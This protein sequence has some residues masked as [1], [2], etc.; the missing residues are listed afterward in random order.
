MYNVVY[1]IIHTIYINLISKQNNFPLKKTQSKFA[2][3]N[4]IIIKIGCN[5]T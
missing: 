2:K 5:G 4:V 1:Y 3:N